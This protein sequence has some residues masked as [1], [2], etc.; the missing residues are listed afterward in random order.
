[1]KKING[2]LD[3]NLT[4]VIVKMTIPIVLGNM[5]QT[6]YNLT[7]T[8]FV[9][10]IGGTQV[11][12]VTFIWPIVFLIISIGQGMSVAGVSIISKSIGEG[13][14]EEVKENI[15]QLFVI[16]TILGIA[17]AVL[18]FLF[19]DTILTSLGIDGELYEESSKYMKIMLLATPAT[20]ITLCQGAV[21][22]SEGN[23]FRP[24]IVNLI[25]ISANVILN[26][27]FIFY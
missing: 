2:I 1:M 9:S 21:R 20:F 24:M 27:I 6:L 25:S 5:I 7:D 12:A 13:K 14:K 18:G 26:P 4:K 11:A 22:R 8:F 10:K 16:A 19:T 3:G 15:G 23:T 17:I